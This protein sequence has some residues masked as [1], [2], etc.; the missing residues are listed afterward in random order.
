MNRKLVDAPR[1]GEAEWRVITPGLHRQDPVRIALFELDEVP[2][3]VLLRVVGWMT[4]S[5]MM[6][7]PGDGAR[8]SSSDRDEPAT[9]ARVDAL[10]AAMTLDE[11]IGQM[12][13][14]DL[15]ALKDKS[16]ILRYA[17]GSVNSGGDSDPPDIT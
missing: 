16:D 8:A 12:T 1:H 14:V 17:L 11:K 7:I 5:A 10:M 15:L 3:N 9:Q 13:Q 4:L 2:M 6:R